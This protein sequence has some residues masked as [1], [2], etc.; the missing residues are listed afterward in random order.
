MKVVV[1]GLGLFGKSLAI[2][3]ARGGNDVLAIDANPELVDD[4]KEEVHVAVSLDATDERE[5]RAQG[6]ADADILV[7]S[8]GDNFEANQLLILTAKQ[9][10]IKRVIARAPS[11]THA[12]I[13]RL[14]G[15]DDVILPEVQAADLAARRI[16][17]P[18][19]KG[20]FQL[21]EGHSVVEIVAPQEF[22][23]RNLAELDLKGKHRVSLVAIT[24]HDDGKPTINTVPRGTEVIRAGDLLALV[25]R[26][27]DLR[28][29]LE[30]SAK[31]GNGRA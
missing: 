30:L 10:G 15:A 19:I 28:G 23:G 2:K 4:V 6:A 27:E 1:V 26:D 9:I 11:E 25:G 8:I 16:V 12:R 5:L 20:Y 29:V 21:V 24:R 31:P 7:A 3:L 18:S 17:E 14:I 13:L 22:D